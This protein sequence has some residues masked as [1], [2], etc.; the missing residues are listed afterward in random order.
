[1]DAEIFLYL[2]GF[3][4]SLC[5]SIMWMVTGKLI[6]VPLYV[7]I[8]Y[9]LMRNL[10]W[11]QALLVT[12]MIGVAVALSDS[13]CSQIIRP[14]I[15]RPRPAQEG[16]PI[17]ALVHIVNDYRG[18][19]YG[20]PSCHAANSACLC[21]FVCRLFRSGGLRV[22]MVFWMLLLCYS[23]IYIGVHYPGDLLAGTAVGFVMAELMYWLTKLLDWRCM[24]KS[25][26]SRLTEPLTAPLFPVLVGAA[27]LLGIIIASVAP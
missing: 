20:M 19:S 3:H 14:L 7:S 5:D 18:G 15:C 22:F 1:M 2:N 8:V 6:W 10:T 27:T 9:V 23:R 11:R 21:W 25:I 4:N 17:A 12:A 26:F 16:S 24:K 13:L